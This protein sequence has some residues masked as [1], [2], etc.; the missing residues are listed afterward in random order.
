MPSAPASIPKRAS[1]TPSSAIAAAG[2]GLSRSLPQYDCELQIGGSDQ[3]GNITTGTDLIH[4]A[5]EASAHVFGTPLIT[6]ADGTKFGKSEGT[7]SGSIPRHAA[8][9]PCTS[10]GSTPT[11]PTSSSAAQG[12]HFPRSCKRSSALEAVR[13]ASRSGGRRS[14]VSHTR[15]PAWFTAPPRRMPRSPPL[16]PSSATA[17]SRPLMPP[18]LEAALRESAEHHASPCSTSGGAG[19]LVDTGLSPSSARPVA[20]LARGRLCQQHQDRG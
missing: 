14:G 11:M 18:T 6:N 1:A 13:E 4:R 7:R 12:V 15:S 9:T 16:R 17:T 19:L 2:L 3:W 10:S 20:P 5:E 8:R